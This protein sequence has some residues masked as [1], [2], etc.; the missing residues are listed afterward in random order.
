MSDLDRWP[1][2]R[3]AAQLIVLPSL[4][5]DV[6]ALAPSIRAGAGG[7]L[8]LGGSST[9][10]DLREQLAAAAG[11][12]DLG[13]APLVMADVEGGG[14]QRLKGAIEAF[15]WARQLATT[16]SVDEV[17]ALGQA[18][19]LEMIAAGVS[20]DLAPVLDLDDGSGPSAT[21]PDGERSFSVDPA[22]TSAYGI[23][24]MKGLRTVGI[25]PVLKHFPGIGQSTHNSDY[26]PAATRPYAELQTG[27]LEPFVDAIAAG[28]PAIMISNAYTPGLTTQPASV[29]PAVIQ[30]LLREQLGFS[31]LVVTDSLSAGAI[32]QA[33]FSVPQAAV[34]SVEA[35][36]DLVL[37]G[38]TLSPA[39]TRL[40]SPANV[41]VTRG[42]ILD[43]LVTAVR[44]GHL[45]SARLDE[46]VAH[47]L[48]AKG[49]SVCK[50]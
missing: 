11:G 47:V 5:F 36:A 14:V 8:F 35:G 41:E 44:A 43:A 7:L 18:V 15:P 32:R 12:G 3:R 33:G 25:V 22:T 26:G 6:E 39:D 20:V 31:G 30:H 38:S 9:P 29:S 10:P 48:S 50:S 13:A 19:G 42:A 23:A 45:P 27:G 1:V 49:V 4:D 2:E 21:D 24:F 46:A 28:A 16:R 37:F 40:L 17:R 34:A